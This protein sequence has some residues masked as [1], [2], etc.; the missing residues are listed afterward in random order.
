MPHK[1]KQLL[2]KQP[3]KEERPQRGDNRGQHDRLCAL[4]CLVKAH[5]IQLTK[6]TKEF[7]HM[8]LNMTQL[9]EKLTAL[10]AAEAAREARDV[11]Q[12]IVTAQNIAALNAAVAALQAIIDAGST[13]PADQAAIDAAVTR[14]EAV[15]ASLDA[16]DPT[17]PVV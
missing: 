6:L 7:A 2:F 3:R 5:T 4:E 8:A 15:I 13:N 10:E 14:V 17:P 12:D 11:A 1:P 16:A 9:Q